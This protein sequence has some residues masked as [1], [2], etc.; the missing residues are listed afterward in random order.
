MSLGTPEGCNCDN[1]LKMN[2]YLHRLYPAKEL[3]MLVMAPSNHKTNMTDK[4]RYRQGL[5]SS[6]TKV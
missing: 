2:F 3:R 6:L 4:D 1:C 5:A